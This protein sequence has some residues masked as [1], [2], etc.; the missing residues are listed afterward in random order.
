MKCDFCGLVEERM[1]LFAHRQFAV[2]GILGVP[3]LFETGSWSVCSKCRP[4]FAA[5]RVD[6]LVRR[7]AER[8]IPQN[9]PARAAALVRRELRLVHDAALKNRLREPPPI[10]TDEILVPRDGRWVP[11]A[12]G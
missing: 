3:A 11:N 5:D 10:V 12:R 7:A 8:L 6:E 9:L 2:V 4:H 1:L